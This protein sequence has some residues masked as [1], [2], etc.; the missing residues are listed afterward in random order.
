MHTQLAVHDWSAGRSGAAMTVKGRDAEG[1]EIK[2]PNVKH[3]GPDISGVVVAT[4]VG[5]QRFKLVDGVAGRLI[6]RLNGVMND[7][8]EPGVKLSNIR[9][10]LDAAI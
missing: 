6:D 1:S 10:L 9:M 4:D 5:N 3:I 2:I 8:A 7:D